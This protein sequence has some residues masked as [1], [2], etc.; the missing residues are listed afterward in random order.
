MKLVYAFVFISVVICA[1]VSDIIKVD[2][3]SSCCA[4][5]YYLVLC[6]SLYQLLLMPISK[7]AMRISSRGS[8][9]ANNNK[10]KIS[11]TKIKTKYS[12]ISHQFNK[13]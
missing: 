12:K 1:V 5:S 11:L 2:L 10:I 4:T 9:I 13:M 3:F 8:E 7:S 6:L